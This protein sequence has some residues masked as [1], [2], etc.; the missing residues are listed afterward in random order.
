M[1]TTRL[2]LN[3]FV[4][5]HFFPGFTPNLCWDDSGVGGETVQQPIKHRGGQEETPSG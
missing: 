3:S 5:N 4:K 2:S 1:Q